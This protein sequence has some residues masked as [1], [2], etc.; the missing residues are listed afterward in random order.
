MK[1]PFTRDQIDD[2]QKKFSKS[3]RKLFRSEFIQLISDSIAN[4]ILQT[5]QHELHAQNEKIKLLKDENKKLIN[6]LRT[7]K[8]AYDNQEQYTRRN[9]LQNLGVKENSKENIG[10][11][12]FINY[13]INI[14]T[15]E[16]DIERVHRVG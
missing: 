4:R 16:D 6:K 13:K 9:S 11:V 15:T 5:I 12:V 7:Q 3:V 2:L 8:V 1:I 14:N 10:K